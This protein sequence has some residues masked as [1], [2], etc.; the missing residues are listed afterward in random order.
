MT[1]YNVRDIVVYITYTNHITVNIPEVITRLSRTL[2]PMAFTIRVNHNHQISH[3]TIK[4]L[5]IGVLEK[6]SG[7]SDET[8]I[9]LTETTMAKIT[10][11]SELFPQ[12]TDVL[13][14]HLNFPNFEKVNEFFIDAKNTPRQYK[15]KF[16]NL[17]YE[18]NQSFGQDSALQRNHINDL[19]QESRRQSKGKLQ[20]KG[21]LAGLISSVVGRKR[22]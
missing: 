13:C 19:I 7:L 18:V 10:L 5:V 2:Q 6:G 20:S 11:E 16:N 14:V 9:L 12:R 17:E 1:I 4:S 21:G 22:D 3:K 15:V 8:K